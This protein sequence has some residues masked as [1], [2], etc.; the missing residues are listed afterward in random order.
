MFGHDKIVRN[1]SVTSLNVFS[2][3]KWKVHMSTNITNFN[4]NYS[5]DT[6]IASLIE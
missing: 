4:E 3:R 1:E 6:I 5:T 2:L